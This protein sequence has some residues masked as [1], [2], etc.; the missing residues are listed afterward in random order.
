MRQA[1]DGDSKGGLNANV[2]EDVDFVHGLVCFVALY[3]VAREIKHK[4]NAHCGMWISDRACECVDDCGAVG[5]RKRAKR[6]QRCAGH[7]RGF[8]GSAAGRRGSSR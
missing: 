2:G 1:N 8:A 3:A 4:A 5:M 6:D 7:A